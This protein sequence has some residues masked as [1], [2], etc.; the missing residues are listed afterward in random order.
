MS[1]CEIIAFKDGKPSEALESRNAWGGAAYVWSCLFDKYLK[2]PN[3]QYDTWLSERGQGRLW[4]LAKKKEIPAFMRAVHASTFDYALV[5]PKNFQRFIDDLREF[6]RYF[7]TNGKV[8]HLETWATFIDQHRDAEA[9]GFYGT[10][11]GENLWFTW[12]EGKEESVPY[13]LASGDKHF[14]VYDELARYDAE[15]VA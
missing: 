9:I 1:Y 7:G 5:L 13:D 4:D 14:D 6:A 10:S 11:V 12:D 8:C 3:N 15:A 2:D